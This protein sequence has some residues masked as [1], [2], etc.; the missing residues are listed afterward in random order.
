MLM[1]GFIAVA[2]ATKCLGIIDMR[3]PDFILR[4][5]F[6]EDGANVKKRKKKGNMQNVPGEASLVGSLKW[7]VAGLGAGESSDLAS[8]EPDGRSD[9]SPSTHRLI[10]QGVRLIATTSERISRWNGC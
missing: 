10:C 1:T 2:F 8:G 5:G 3:G 9:A 7:V 4:E 6:N